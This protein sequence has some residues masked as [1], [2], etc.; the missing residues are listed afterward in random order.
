[1]QTYARNL[2]PGD[3]LVA[4][5]QTRRLEDVED[6][7]SRTTRLTFTDGTVLDSAPD[8]VVV[9]RRPTNPVDLIGLVANVQTVAETELEAFRADLEG[10]GTSFE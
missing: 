10:W 7:D 6:V 5:A 1:M 8:Q 3:V 4:N 2:E 9:Y